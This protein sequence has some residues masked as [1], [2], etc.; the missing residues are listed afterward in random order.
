MFEAAHKQDHLLDVIKHGI[1]V[2]QLVPA[3]SNTGRLTGHQQA[4]MV[5]KV[6][7]G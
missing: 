3:L 6:P 5:R 1:R 2:L 7:E 4:V